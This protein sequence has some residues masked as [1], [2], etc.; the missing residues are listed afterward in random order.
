LEI[1]LHGYHPRDII[2]PS[3]LT[4]VVQQ[5]WETGEASRTIIHGHGRYRGNGPGYVNTNTGYL[6][7]EIRRALRCNTD[8][9]Q[10]IKYTTLFC[11][12]PGSTSVKLKPNPS[13]SRTQLGDDLLP[14]RHYRR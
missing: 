9:R 2:W 7:L 1:D 8:L 13:P 12:K 11:A 3:V 5:A 14:D 10:W 4:N 6:G